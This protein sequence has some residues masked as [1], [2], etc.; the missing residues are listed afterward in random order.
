MN[1]PTLKSDSKD[2]E[3]WTKK[4]KMGRIKYGLVYGSL[5]GLFM[6]VIHIFLDI[7]ESRSEFVTKEIIIRQIY[8]IPFGII[9][10]MT[11]IWWLENKFS[12]KKK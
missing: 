5:F 2:S 12:R 1:K 11:V 4:R 9:M 6:L 8:W 3:A 7:R 10:F